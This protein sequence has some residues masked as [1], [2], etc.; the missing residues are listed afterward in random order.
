MAKIYN[1][2]VEKKVE[3]FFEKTLGEGYTV[4]KTYIVSQEELDKIKP[5]RTYPNPDFVPIHV[6]IDK[7]GFLEVRDIVTEACELFKKREV[8]DRK[9]CVLGFKTL[10]K[11]LDINQNVIDKLINFSKDNNDEK[12]R[13]CITQ[14]NIRLKHGTKNK[15]GVGLNKKLNCV[16]DKLVN[17]QIKNSNLN[18]K[19]PKNGDC[20]IIYDILEKLLDIEKIWELTPPEP[21]TIT[22]PVGGLYLSSGFGKYPKSSVLISVGLCTDKNKNEFEQTFVHE[23]THAMLHAVLGDVISKNKGL[24]EGFAVAMEYFYAKQ[25]ALKFNNKRHGEYLAYQILTVLD[26]PDTLKELFD[27]LNKKHGC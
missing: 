24:N 14:F 17:I 8:C 9:N 16:K 21:P 25:N 26:S 22:S 23:H 5:P 1:G 27:E 11:R 7:T 3:E 15:T 2:K 19:C 6:A 18:K 20:E 13:Q 4:C 12:I 10:C